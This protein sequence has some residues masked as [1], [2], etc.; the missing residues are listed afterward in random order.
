MFCIMDSAGLCPARRELSFVKV[1]T[2]IIQWQAKL[3]SLIKHVGSF[4]AQTL[5]PPFRLTQCMFVRAMYGYSYSVLSFVYAV[6][7]SKRPD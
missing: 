6:L 1:V 4:C 5:A 7:R 3:V 2:A